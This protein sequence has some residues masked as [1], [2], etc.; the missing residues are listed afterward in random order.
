MLSPRGRGSLP[1]H[2]ADEDALLKV[3]S[4]NVRRVR[5]S[6]GLSQ[7]ALADLADLDRTYVSSI[8]RMRR[9]VSIKNIQRLAIALQVDPRDLLDPAAAAA[10]SNR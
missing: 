7:E 1:P 10:V 4:S 6:R 3:F 8:E 2:E 9:N 5:Q